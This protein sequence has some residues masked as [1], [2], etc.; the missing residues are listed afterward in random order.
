M[1]TQRMNLNVIYEF[2]VSTLVHQLQQ[3]TLIQMLIVGEKM[4]GKW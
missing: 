2:N 3:M 1:L 4:H